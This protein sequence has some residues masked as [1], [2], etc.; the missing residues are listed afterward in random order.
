MA[1]MAADVNALAVVQEPLPFSLP[2]AVSSI[3]WLAVCQHGH[4]TAAV[5]AGMSVCSLFGMHST[6]LS[7]AN[8]TT[9][10]TT[11]PSCPYPCKAAAKATTSQ[12]HHHTNPLLKECQHCC[13]N[14]HTPHWPPRPHCASLTSWSRVSTSTLSE[15]TYTTSYSS[16]MPSCSRTQHT[17]RQIQYHSLTCSTVSVQ[18]Q[19]DAGGSGQQATHVHHAAGTCDHH[20]CDKQH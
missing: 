3:S 18:H 5:A 6:P 1:A 20:L 19:Y 9:C 17:C 12:T 10:G 15:P 11:P 16:G 14:P 7:A 4:L 2:C 8:P 13:C